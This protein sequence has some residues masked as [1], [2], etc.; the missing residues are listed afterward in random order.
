MNLPRKDSWGLSVLPGTPTGFTGLHVCRI[1][2]AT[3]YTSVI[4][5]ICLGKKYTS[6]IH[7]TQST[8][9]A[10]RYGYVV[11]EYR[12]QTKPAQGD[13]AK[14]S[15][16][17]LSCGVLQTCTACAGKKWAATARVRDIL[18]ESVLDRD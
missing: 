14:H 11:L 6:V 15:R 7:N 1:Y 16:S 3:V 9:E 10:N 8:R 18:P 2:L 4:H 12:A 17:N 13:N 5:R